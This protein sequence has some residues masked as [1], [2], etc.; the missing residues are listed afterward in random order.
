MNDNNNDKNIRIR[1]YAYLTKNNY[2][3]PYLTF[4]NIK[5]GKIDNWCAG[6]YCGCKIPIPSTKDLKLITSKEYNDASILLS[7]ELNA[8][9][10]LKTNQEIFE[11]LKYPLRGYDYDCKNYSC[12]YYNSK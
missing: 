12:K 4:F 3:R 7:D 11:Y 8:I 2:C 9:G 5:N 10:H 1:T 6:V